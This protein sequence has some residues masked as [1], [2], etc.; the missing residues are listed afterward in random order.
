MFFTKDSF[1][2]IHC[3]P[4]NSGLHLSRRLK[5]NVISC[6]FAWEP[7]PCFT[8]TLPLSKIIILAVCFCFFK[9]TLISDY[10]VSGSN[11]SERFYPKWLTFRLAFILATG[12]RV[13]NTHDSYTINITS[14]DPQKDISMRKVYGLDKSLR[15]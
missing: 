8:A 5:S 12:R 6:F 4:L 1:S 7:T 13:S 15:E 9:L 10:Y 11:S 14:I 2:S 3:A